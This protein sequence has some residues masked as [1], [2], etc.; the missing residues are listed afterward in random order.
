[1]PTTEQVQGQTTWWLMLG[2]GNRVPVDRNTT[3]TRAQ[4]LMMAKAPLRYG[5]VCQWGG[6]AEVPHLLNPY[7]GREVVVKESVECPE[8]GAEVNLGPAHL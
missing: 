2:N 3:L 5:E 6:T 4:H 7:R 8:C 1:M